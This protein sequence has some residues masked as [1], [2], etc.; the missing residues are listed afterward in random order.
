[1]ETV[2]GGYMPNN[3]YNA[4]CDTE[5]CLNELKAL[6]GVDLDNDYLRKWG[7]L[8]IYGDNRWDWGTGETYDKIYCPEC[9]K[10]MEMENENQTPPGV[11]TPG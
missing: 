5:G 9:R 6:D 11:Q 2:T 4:I 10:K 1:V 7:W 3:F 8:V